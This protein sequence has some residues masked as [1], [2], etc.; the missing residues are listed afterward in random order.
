[1]SGKPTVSLNVRISPHHNALLEALL[2]RSDT[3]WTLKRE[4]VEAAIENL[5]QAYRLAPSRSTM[6]ALGHQ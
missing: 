2:N 1:M 5:D 6:P 4:L 3:I